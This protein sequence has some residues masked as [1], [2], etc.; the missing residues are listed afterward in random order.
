MLIIKELKFYI[1]LC[2]LSKT[3]ILSLTREN[4]A[5]FIKKN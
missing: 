1:M 3:V 5:S 4:H 2:Q